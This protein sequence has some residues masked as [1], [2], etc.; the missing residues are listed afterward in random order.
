MIYEVR[1]N[2]DYTSR[3]CAGGLWLMIPHILKHITPQARE[4]LRNYVR[5]RTTYTEIGSLKP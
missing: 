5:E 1:E 2:G 4:K 3:G